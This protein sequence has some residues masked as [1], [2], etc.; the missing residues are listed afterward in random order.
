[1]NRLRFIQGQ[2]WMTSDRSRSRSTWHLGLLPFSFLIFRLSY[3]LAYGKS[4]NTWIR[5]VRIKNLPGPADQTRRSMEYLWITRRSGNRELS[6]HLNL[7]VTHRSCTNDHLIVTQRR[8]M[9][10]GA[11]SARW[12][13]TGGGGIKGL[14]VSG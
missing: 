9:D 10:V 1:M 2:S 4:P 8:Q 14:H 7:Q 6:V 12:H 13:G 5:Q 3:N 11:C